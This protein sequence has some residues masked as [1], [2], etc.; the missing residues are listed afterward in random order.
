MKTA[1]RWQPARPQ[2]G[3]GLV[4]VLVSVALGLGLV[5]AATVLV[6][7]ARLSTGTSDNLSR[8]QDAVRTSHDLLA[9][10]VREAGATPCD[11]DGDVANVLAHAQGAAPT[12]WASWTEPLRGYGGAEP[13]PGAPFGTGTGQR[14]AGTDALVVRRAVALDLARVSAH[15]AVGA[16]FTTGV[17]DPGIA[18][19]ALLMACNYQQAAIF[20]VTAVNGAAGTF[21]HAS[22]GTGPGNCSTGLGLLPGCLAAG[23]GYQFPAGSGLGTFTVVGW[24]VGHNGRPQSGGRSLYRVTQ[25]GPQEVA[26][27]VRNLQLSYL[28][29]GSAD[30]VPAAAVST[31]QWAQKGVVA[32]RVELGYEGPQTGVITTAA[33][34]RLRRDVGYTV[35]LRNLQP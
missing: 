16:R 29:S 5:G 19:G 11:A 32:V 9:R 6:L 35:N 22:G 4:E 7:S 23:N 31:A 24:Y 28:V 18:V 2:R 20:Q 1:P 15:D 21:D 8:M 14:V 34:Q 30:Y 13:F 26:E 10:E 3:L 17:A 27:G 12:W 25:T 33:A